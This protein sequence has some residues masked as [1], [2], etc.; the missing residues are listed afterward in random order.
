MILFRPELI[1]I[2]AGFDAHDDDP[3]SNT[4]L[5]EDDFAWATRIVVDASRSIDAVNPP[6]ILSSLEGGYNL[7][8]L[9]LSAAAHVNVLADCNIVTSEPEI[10]DHGGDEV[11]ALSAHVKS[12]GL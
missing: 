5:T 10:S 4:T 7:D 9:A 6:P 11:A 12:L 8:A 2:S 1:I 3:L